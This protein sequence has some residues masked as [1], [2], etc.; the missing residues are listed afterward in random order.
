VPSTLRLHVSRILGGRA[1][2]AEK[3]QT[4]QLK[5]EVAGTSR[6]EGAEFTEKELDAAMK[7]SPE[8][9]ETRSQKQVAAAVST[10]KW[11]A[12]LPA[13][14]PVDEKLILEVH[15]VG[16]LDEAQSLALL[17]RIHVDVDNRRNRRRLP[18]PTR[19]KPLEFM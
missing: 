1:S 11:I 6:I 3:L 19:L 4:V 15:R 8:Q 13:D 18:C 10:Y 9:L 7:E 16:K 17:G 12:S 2:W 5:R 14:K